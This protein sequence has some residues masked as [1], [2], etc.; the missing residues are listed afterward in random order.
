M[1]GQ[2]LFHSS[3][4]VPFR[5]TPNMQH[6]ITRVGVEGVVSAAATAIAHSLTLPEFDLASTLHLFIR[7]EIL[8][9]QNTYNKGSADKHADTPLTAHVYKNVDQFI[10][11]AE[12]M[13]HMGE[14]K[15]K[16]AGGPA[17]NH[18]MV[19]L[20]SQAT[21]PTLLASMSETFMAWF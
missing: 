20:I 7:D 12:L 6:F 9:W 18:A 11:R 8:T 4:A 21:A 3:E 10:K 5:L 19:T 16:V 2:P 17:I 15:D 1:Q 13:G 14:V